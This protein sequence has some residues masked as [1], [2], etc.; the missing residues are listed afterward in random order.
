MRSPPTGRSSSTGWASAERPLS[1]PP[2]AGPR[3]SAGRGIKSIRLHSPAGRPG[4]RP[5]LLNSLAGPGSLRRGE[6]RARFCLS[7]CSRRLSDV[8]AVRA[9]DVLIGALADHGG[10]VLPKSVFAHMSRPSHGRGAYTPANDTADNQR[11]IR[12]FRRLPRRLESS[13]KPSLR[14][15]GSGL[16]RRSGRVEGGWPN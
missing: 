16:A 7:W 10:N 3:G 5:I 4:A 1:L 8:T 15:A 9:R 12:M 13:P 11:H 2:S 6:W 14:R